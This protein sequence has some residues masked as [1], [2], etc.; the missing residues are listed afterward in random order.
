MTIGNAA[1]WQ[2]IARIRLRVAAMRL[3]GRSFVRRQLVNESQHLFALTLLVGLVCGLAAVAFHLSIRAAES[4]LID[5]AMHATGS[6]WMLWTVASPTIGGLLAG[7]ALTWLVPGAR[8]SGIPQVK[9]AFAVE[10]GRIRLRDALGKFII[11]AV[12]I[13]SGA[14]LGREGP[15]VHICAGATSALA[16]ATSLAPRNMRRL[17]PVGVAAGIAAAFNAPIAAVTFTIEEVVG[18]LD[19]SVLSGVVVAAALAAVIER[20]ILG[21]HPVI[22]VSQVYGFDHPSSLALFAVLG[23]AAAVV[24]VVFTDGLLGLRDWFRGLRV[25][26]AWMQPAVGGLV[27]GSLAVV[28]LRFF[29]TTGVTGGGYE[30]LGRA[31]AGQLGFR[32][33]I[34]LCVAKLAATLFSY[35]SGG[36]GGIFAPALFVGAMLGGAVGHLDVLLL[37]HER[38]QIGAF[39]LVGMGAVFAGVIR[40]P[41]TSVLIIFEMTGGYGLVLPLM[42]A[43]MTAYAIARHWRPTPI[44]EALLEQDGVVLPHATPPAHAL[45]QLLV[46]DAMTTEGVAARPQPSGPATGVAPPAALLRVSTGAPLVPVAA[47]KRSGHVIRSDEPLLRAAVRM[48]HLGVRQ[49]PVVDAES[50]TRLV[51]MLTMSDVV[52]AHARATPVADTPPTHTPRPASI[53]ELRARAVMLAAALVPGAAKVSELLAQLRGGP[54]RAFVVR[55]GARGFGVILSEQL[56]E[57]A[58]DENLERLLNAADLARK[59]SIQDEGADLP[60]LVRVMQDDGTEAAV[61]LDAETKEPIG[62]VTKNAMAVAFLD[63]YASEATRLSAGLHPTRGLPDP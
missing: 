21:A 56:D 19:Q 7:A 40:A 42:L 8:G 38:S 50:E 27:T 31:L 3:A 26:P 63:W 28:M 48:K 17:T 58:R 61:V 45:E 52:R 43:N 10:G 59:A 13:G 35:S 9:Q 44:Y 6:A 20:G 53:P 5:R 18:T 39:A 57:F 54:A 12:Q 29:G 24:S 46:S 34:F 1:M 47:L 4:L 22:E 36:A 51:G 30:T 49:L 25:V 33:L 16:R 23:V 60:T 37:H 11:A 55:E 62:V 15:T 32:V 14:S 2:G 41:I